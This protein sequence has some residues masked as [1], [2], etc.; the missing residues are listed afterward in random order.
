MLNYLINKQIERKGKLILIF[1]DLRAAFNSVDRKQISETM[2]RRDVREGLVRR[3]EEVLRETRSK[4]KVGDRQ[5]ESFWMVRGVRQGCPPSL[6]TLLLADVEEM[7]GSKGWGEVKIGGKKIYMLAYADDM[8]ML[9]EDGMKGLIGVME[10][11]LD[12]KG[13]ELNT[14]KTKVIRCKRGGDRWKKMRLHWKGKELEEVKKFKYLGYVVMEVK[15][16]TSE[17]E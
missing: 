6:F 7:F 14:K 1:M 5:G 2:R 16:L 3:C 12:G 8:M 15:K 13:L 10:R 9:A 17:I 4:V 11:Y